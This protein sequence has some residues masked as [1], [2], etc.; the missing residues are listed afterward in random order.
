MSNEKT[1]KWMITPQARNAVTL[2]L[3]EENT[4]DSIRFMAEFCCENRKCSMSELLSQAL[5][6][7][8]KIIRAPLDTSVFNKHAE[9]RFSE[10]EELEMAR[11][12]ILNLFAQ[13]TMV[14]EGAYNHQCRCVYKQAQK[15]LL[16][17]NLIKEE[18]CALGV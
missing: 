8:N 3:L 18:D 16:K 9:L 12:L 5:S 17:K 13:A 7:H 11:G 14:P 10:M 6:A 1:Y 2:V 4:P 15:Y